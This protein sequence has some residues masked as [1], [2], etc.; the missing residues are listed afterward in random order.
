TD[1]LN[2]VDEHVDLIEHIFGRHRRLD[3]ERVKGDNSRR[4]DTSGESLA[5]SRVDAYPV[6]RAEKRGELHARRLEEE[7]DRSRPLAIA[8]RV[9]GEQT[10]SFSANQM[11]RVA[12]QDFDA[13]NDATRGLR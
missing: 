3:I 7:I 11:Q 2:V 12:Q 10:D 9:I 13:G 1:V 4:I 5:R 6:L 8:S